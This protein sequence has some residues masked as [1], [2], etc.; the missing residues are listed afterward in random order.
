[1]T[2][3]EGSVVMRRAAAPWRRVG[4]DVLIAPRGRDDFDLLTGVAARAWLLLERDVSAQELDADFRDGLADLR[5]R[6]LVEEV[7]P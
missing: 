2:G 5:S 7:R 4:D 3:T 1:M 6:G